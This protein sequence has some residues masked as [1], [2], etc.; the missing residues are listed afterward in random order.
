MQEMIENEAK[1]VVEIVENNVIKDKKEDENVDDCLTPS[2]DIEMDEL[3]E[4]DRS[5]E[6]EAEK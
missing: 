3:N 5:K 6:S 4:D 2:R 1:E